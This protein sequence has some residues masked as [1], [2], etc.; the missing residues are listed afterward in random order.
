MYI[1]PPFH[2]SKITRHINKEE[3]WDDIEGRSINGHS[4]GG[5]APFIRK[6]LSNVLKPK[7][8]TSQP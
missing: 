3:I 6:L 8:K 1:I 2:W 4:D 5:E 7:S